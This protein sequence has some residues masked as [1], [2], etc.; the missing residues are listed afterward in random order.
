MCLQE[1][2]ME[3][4]MGRPSDHPSFGDTQLD[5]NKLHTAHCQF[6]QLHPATKYRPEHPNP[7]PPAYQ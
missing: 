7:H 2:E 6:L 3:G 4:K 5:K 1:K